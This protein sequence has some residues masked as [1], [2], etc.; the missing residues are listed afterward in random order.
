MVP[1]HLLRHSGAAE[2][3][4]AFLTIRKTMDLPGQVCIFGRMI[5]LRFTALGLALLLPACGT[6]R[7]G[8]AK[9]SQPEAA[10]P[11]PFGPTG[12][13]AHLRRTEA[14]SAAA[15]GAG[16]GGGNVR[17]PL[18]DLT[19]VDQL[20]FTNPD[21]P[22]ASL[23]ELSSILVAPSKGP[24]ETD[25]KLARRRSLSEGKPLLIWFTDSSGASPLCRTLDKELFNTTEFE[26]W[27]S[28][29]LVRLRV[30]SIYNERV[31]GL[32]IDEQFTYNIDR[33]RRVAELK[34]RYKILGHPSLV[35]LKPDGEVVG[36]YRGYKR[37]QADYFWGLMKHGEA[38]AATA[39]ASW[40]TD[41]EKK[42]YRT[43]SDGRDRRLFAK[44]LSYKD[45][46]LVLIEPDGTRS[47]TRESSLSS[48]DRKWIDDQ[49]AA[50]G[51][52]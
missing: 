29:R 32:S 43:W 22:E 21:D 10:E 18:E 39:F 44:L 48:D 31:E 17:V 11:S 36:R 16:S 47:R 5:R 45:G 12:I 33:R 26:S 27:A 19:P 40:R 50:R 28:S 24:W 25:E 35:M 52:Q 3:V 51:L 1:L 13:P 8:V 2:K 20:V 46:Q 14:E 15:A 7:T 38:V 49:K 30:D 41:M 4:A 9:L 34:K 37:G 6:V 42:G 23:L